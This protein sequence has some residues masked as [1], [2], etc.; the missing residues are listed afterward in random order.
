MTDQNFKKKGIYLRND[1]KQY[2]LNCLCGAA[3]QKR[4]SCTVNRLL[5]CKNIKVRPQLLL[6]NTAPLNSC[7]EVMTHI[8][9]P[10][11]LRK[12]PT[13]VPVSY[14]MP[15]LCWQSNAG[16]FHTK[17]CRAKSY[18]PSVIY[19]WNSFVLSCGNFTEETVLG[20]WRKIWMN[21]F[22]YVCSVNLPW[23]KIVLFEAH[24]S[25]RSA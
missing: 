1:K 23:M 3:I 18:E 19:T 10:H 21:L 2:W 7:G 24:W 17:A 6:N 25:I 22:H 8:L 16:Q 11:L 15:E 12:Q 14:H 5:D 4:R 9:Y 20:F 13:S